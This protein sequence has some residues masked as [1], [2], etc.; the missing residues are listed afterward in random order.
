M[1]IPYA[2]C[3]MP[4]WAQSHM[5]TRSCYR[6]LVTH[7]IDQ[8]HIV[9][10]KPCSFLCGRSPNSRALRGASSPTTGGTGP[11]A[12]GAPAPTSTQPRATSSSQ[13]CDFTWCDVYAVRQAV[14][15]V[16]QR[17]GTVQCRAVLDRQGT[18]AL[19]LGCSS[20]KFCICDKH[21]RCTAGSREPWVLAGHAGQIAHLHLSHCFN[22]V[23]S[24]LWNLGPHLHHV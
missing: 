18:R 1:P 12:T 23:T 17:A 15:Q 10:S 5:H 16:A 3:C 4:S 19:R 8:L 13:R 20:S 11:H 2:T 21:T 22:H 6:Q 7:A 14:R 9:G 24:V